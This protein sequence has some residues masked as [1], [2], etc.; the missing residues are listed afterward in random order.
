LEGIADDQLLIALSQAERLAGSSFDHSGQTVCHTAV[1][2][3]TDRMSGSVKMQL[4]LSTL[5]G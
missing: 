3:N 5:I 1:T 2:R 4:A